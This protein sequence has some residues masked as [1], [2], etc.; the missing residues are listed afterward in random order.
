LGT[1]TQGGGLRAFPVVYAQDVEAAAR[2][3]EPLLA[4]LVATLRANT[5]TRASDQ[6]DAGRQQLAAR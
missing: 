3:W 6:A 5:L 4:W 1:V 2:F